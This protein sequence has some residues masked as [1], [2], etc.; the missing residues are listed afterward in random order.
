MVGGQFRFVVGVP[1]HPIGTTAV[2]VQ[3][4]AVEVPAELVAQQGAQLLERRRPGQGLMAEAA[5]AVGAA[6]IAVPA[7]QPRHR[8]EPA[9]D[10]HLGLLPGNAGAQQ[11]PVQQ[12]AERWVQPAWP[13]EQ[14]EAR[15]PDPLGGL[16]QG[17]R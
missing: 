1:A 9:V 11:M 8:M 6:R 15:P 12:A 5:V 17:E 14:R 7:N 16:R 2:A 3:Q 10:L 13:M 4:Q